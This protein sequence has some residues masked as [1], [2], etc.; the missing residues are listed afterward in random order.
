M[1]RGENG[2]QS[3][4]RVGLFFGLEIGD[5][6]K[7]WGTK[8]VQAQ[9]EPPRHRVTLAR[10]VERG[11]FPRPMRING[12]NFWFEDEARAAI[13]KLAKRG[14]QADRAAR[15]RRRKATAGEAELLDVES[16]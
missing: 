9:W 15:Q 14:R 1:G 4:F 11:E 7:M 10:M 6:R 13:A 5:M 2:Q 12:R 16:V 8:I 3:R